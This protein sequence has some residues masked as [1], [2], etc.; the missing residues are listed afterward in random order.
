MEKIT[1]ERCSNKNLW[2][3]KALGKTYDV[4]GETETDYLVRI[5]PN[6]KNYSHVRKTDAEKLAD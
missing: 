1:V 6:A 3:F 5:K 2:Y 4:E